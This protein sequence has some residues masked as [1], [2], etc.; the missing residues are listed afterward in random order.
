MEAWLATISTPN[1]SVI[2]KLLQPS[3][4]LSIPPSVITKS[5]GPSLSLCVPICAC[6]SLLSLPSYC[7]PLCPCLSLFVV[8]QNF[9]RMML[10]DVIWAI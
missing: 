3:L 9:V 1:K 10:Y 7:K 2:T 5:L 4:S 8:C 6:L